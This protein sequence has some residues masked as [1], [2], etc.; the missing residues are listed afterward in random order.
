MN[1]Q[2][3]AFALENT[4]NE[5]EKVCPEVSNTF[6]FKEDGKIIAKDKNTDEETIN[7]TVGAFN[8]IAERANTMGGLESVTFHDANGQ[9]NITFIEDFYLATVT[10]KEAD[11]KY[12]TALTRVLVPTVLKLIEKIHPASIDSATLATLEPE[13]AGDSD[14]DKIIGGT[15]DL[16]KEQPVEETDMTEPEPEPIEEESDSEV[17]PEP[18]LPEPPVNQFIVENLGGLVIPSD[19]VRIGTAVIEQWKNLYSDKKI[20]EVDVETLNGKTTRCKF[21]PIKDSKYEGKGIIQMP[22]KIQRTLQTT[23]GELVMVKPVVK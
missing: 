9:V 2:V 7:R 18:L 13:L 11:E 4:L 14:V 21:K 8:A 10:S 6:I 16:E 1:N 5:I 12:V 23:K 19:T 15:E 22:Q 20:E 17:N 3:Y